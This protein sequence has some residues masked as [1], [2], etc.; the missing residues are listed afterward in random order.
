MYL[1]SV[2]QMDRSLPKVT[3]NPNQKMGCTK[4]KSQL[5]DKKG[6]SNNEIKFEFEVEKS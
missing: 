2:N 1:V 6:H 4:Q 3:K 5:F